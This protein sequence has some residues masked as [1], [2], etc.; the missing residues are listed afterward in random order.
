M[1]RRFAA[2]A[3]AGL[4][5]GACGGGGT[6]ADGGID[7]AIELDDAGPEDGGPA[8]A[9]PADAG[10]E[11]D[12]GAP[13]PR[14]MARDE[15]RAGVADVELARDAIPAATRTGAEFLDLDLLTVRLDAVI[16]EKIGSPIDIAGV[17]GE[18]SMPTLSL[19]VPAVATLVIAQ[20]LDVAI[21]DLESLLGGTSWATSGDAMVR[22][23]GDAA[24]ALHERLN[25]LR[26]LMW[27]RLRELV[28]GAAGTSFRDVPGYA[29]ERTV[30]VLGSTTLHFVVEGN[31]A[32]DPVATIDVDCGDFPATIRVVDEET[33][34]EVLAS[35]PGVPGMPTTA[36]LPIGSDD[37]R[38]LRAEI[39]V[40]DALGW[41]PCAVSVLGHRHFRGASETID[42]G[43]QGAFAIANMDWIVHTSSIQGTLDAGSTLDAGRVATL[44]RFLRE[45]SAAASRVRRL[46]TTG[47]IDAD[48]Y[49]IHEMVIRRVILGLSSRLRAD[50]TIMGETSIVEG[51]MGLESTC[52]TMLDESAPGHM[53]AAT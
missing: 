47:A 50:P 18:K 6:P 13:G 45:T 41:D 42:G 26:G 27:A 7:A 35:T 52:G 34:A 40:P 16:G 22:A 2:L 49:E 33:G 38:A 25:V 24:V 8:D 32:S 39:S 19:T 11:G 21:E 29:D 3:A 51:L 44:E 12:A 23:L 30:D 4:V 10:P 5:M 43:E 53:G 31:S 28:D 15:A 1:D 48:D 14:T 17:I 20:E 46:E 36:R 9:G 37:P